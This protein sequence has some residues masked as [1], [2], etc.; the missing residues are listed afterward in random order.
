MFLRSTLEVLLQIPL[1]EDVK[2]GANKRVH[3]FSDT[4]LQEQPIQC[5]HY[6]TLHWAKLPTPCPSPLNKHKWPA[7]LG[8][9]ESNGAPPMSLHHL[10][11]VPC[12]LI[13]FPRQ[14]CEAPTLVSLGCPN[15][16]F[17]PGLLTEQP[18][19]FLLFFYLFHFCCHNCPSAFY[20][21]IFIVSTGHFVFA[22]CFWYRYIE[23]K[24]IN[25]YIGFFR[26]CMCKRLLTLQSA[27]CPLLPTEVGSLWSTLD[28][29]PLPTTAALHTI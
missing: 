4:A 6:H 17:S 27:F 12:L 28:D 1:L 11:L 24:Y 13:P 7:V 18:I 15:L 19:C 10:F 14:V 29:S 9:W 23:N 3:L 16:L 26:L 22:R 25:Q 5:S 8:S 20:L 21:Y 2:T